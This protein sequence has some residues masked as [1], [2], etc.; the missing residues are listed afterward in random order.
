MQH[1]YAN[2]SLA[3]THATPYI[4]H[5]TPLC[6]Q[7]STRM[8]DKSDKPTPRIHLREFWVATINATND[9]IAPVKINDLYASI[10]RV[11][12][13]LAASGAS[14]WEV[15]LLTAKLLAQFPDETQVQ[16]KPE[17]IIALCSL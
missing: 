15:D 12:K 10:D 13:M 3:P 11:A 1:S 8:V 5:C 17:F 7:E 9:P 4:T 14:E 16:H 6:P 2:K